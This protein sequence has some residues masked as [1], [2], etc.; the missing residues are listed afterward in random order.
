MQSSSKHNGEKKIQNIEEDVDVAKLKKDY[1]EKKKA[2]SD[3]S[4]NPQHDSKQLDIGW[5][6]YQSAIAEYETL[7]YERLKSLGNEKKK[8]LSETSAN[9]GLNQEEVQIQLDKM[10][11]YERWKEYAKDDAH[12]ESVEKSPQHAWLFENVTKFNRRKRKDCKLI[13]DNS[14]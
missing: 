8:I 11:A 2:F 14:K 10:K 12:L 13:F 1:E 5:E 7:K 4:S 3:L 6:T 9:M